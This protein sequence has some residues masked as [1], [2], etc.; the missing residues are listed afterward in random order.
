[1]D[2]AARRLGLQ[3]LALAERPSAFGAHL[4]RE[5]GFQSDVTPTPKLYLARISGR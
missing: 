5:P 1:M 3:H 2:Q 4:D